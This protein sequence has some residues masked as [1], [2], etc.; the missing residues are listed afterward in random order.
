MNRFPCDLINQPTSVSQCKL[1]PPLQPPFRPSFFDWVL[2]Y[3]VPEH[4]PK[5]RSQFPQ[6]PVS[7]PPDE[8]NTCR[9]IVVGSVSDLLLRGG[10]CWGVCSARGGGCGLGRCCF[11]FEG[12]V[13]VNWGLGGGPY[14]GGRRRVWGES[15]FW[16]RKGGDVGDLMIV[17]V[18]GGRRACALKVGV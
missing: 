10:M 7:I 15:I 1:Q 12:L 9:H 3:I 6:P 13:W 14:D 5:P 18:A 4:P 17:R 11:C 8:G 16:G 2:E